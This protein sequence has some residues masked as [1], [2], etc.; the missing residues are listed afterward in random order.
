MN[1]LPAQAPQMPRARNQGTSRTLNRGT[2]KPQAHSQAA[3]DL[4]AAILSTKLS[5]TNEQNAPTLLPPQALLPPQQK[6]QRPREVDEVDEE[7]I[8]KSGGVDGFRAFLSKSEAEANAAYSPTGSAG[9][10]SGFDMATINGLLLQQTNSAVEN[11]SNK[12][13]DCCESDTK[14][15][16]KVI[17]SDMVN[18]FLIMFGISLGFNA[19][20]YFGVF[21]KIGNLFSSGSELLTEG[22]SNLGAGSTS[23]PPPPPPHLIPS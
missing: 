17:P 16:Y 10:Q 23:L 11:R 15:R 3:N 14:K 20:Q 12:Q 18:F 8:P 2:P 9:V 6:S 5:E 21:G 22:A 1:N 13:Q 7:F 4:N 19:L